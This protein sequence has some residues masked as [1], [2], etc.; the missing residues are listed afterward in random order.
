[1][2]SGN[3]FKEPPQEVPGFVMEAL[4]DARR[5]DPSL[6]SKEYISH[7]GHAMPTMF[8][9]GHTDA[10]F[11]MIDNRLEAQQIMHHG[12]ICRGYRPIPCGWAR[13]NEL[14]AYHKSLYGPG[15]MSRQGTHP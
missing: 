1:M 2:A 10:V 15:T 6:R 3:P 4:R 9:L 14:S 11:W 8:W 13:Y 5:E 7:P 12:A